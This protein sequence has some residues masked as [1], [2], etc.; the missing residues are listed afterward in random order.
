M[1]QLTIIFCT[2]H[3]EAL[4]RRALASVLGM[5]GLDRVELDVVVVDNSDQETARPVVGPFARA[6]VPVRYVAA[7][8]ANIS[9]ARNAGIKAA[10]SEFVAFLDDDMVVEE[11]WLDAV[12]E[13]IGN[14]ALDVWFG[15]V[16]PDFEEPEL[17]IPEA[18]AMFTRKVNQPAG[19]ELFA[20]GPQKTRGFALATSNSVYRR[21][22]AFSDDQPFDPEFGACGGEDLDLFCRL[23]RRGLRFGWVPEAGTREFVPAHRCDIA[24]LARR[25]YAGAQAYVAAEAGNSDHPQIAAQV[26]QL[27]AMVQLMQLSLSAPVLWLSGEEERD[28]LKVRAAAIRGKLFWRRLFPLYQ[29]EARRL[30]HARPGSG[31]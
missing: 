12:L 7:H 11:G 1:T 29:D 28:R 30:G 14:P 4:L 13:A 20:M 27:K 18:R 23:Q 21:A 6:G 10:T 2:Y 15:P 22:R 24:Y 5:R 26:I 25:H 9:V 8:P 16:Q 19:T 3:R 31:R 17:A